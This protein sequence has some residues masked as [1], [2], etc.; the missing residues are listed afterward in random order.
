MSALR[1][2]LETWFRRVWTELDESAIDEMLVP[3]GKA[4]G[5]GA[6]V[7]V[8]PA[9]FKQFR[10]AVCA[11]V[12]DNVITV[13]RTVE[14]GDWISAVCTMNGKSC[15]TGLPVTMTGSVMVRVVDGKLAEAYNHWDFLAL[16]GQLGSVP[17]DTFQRALSGERVA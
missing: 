6:N 8:G 11:L 1:E 13:D 3:D 9:Q 12:S 17:Q 2:V 16:F 7:I 15:Q 14:E 10:T 5:L 4:R